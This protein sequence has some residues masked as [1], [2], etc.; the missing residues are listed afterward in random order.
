[1][2]VHHGVSVDKNKLQQRIAEYE[3]ELKAPRAQKTSASNQ[4]KRKTTRDGCVPRPRLVLRDVGAHEELYEATYRLRCLDE[5][6]AVDIQFLECTELIMAKGVL[7]DLLRLDFVGAYLSDLRLLVSSPWNF[8]KHSCM[9]LTDGYG[10]ELM[11]TGIPMLILDRDNNKTTV[12]SIGSGL[13]ACLTN[14]MSRHGTCLSQY[15]S[16]FVPLTQHALISDQARSQLHIVRLF[17]HVK[18]NSLHRGRISRAD[19][20]LPPR[21]GA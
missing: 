17:I 19:S 20:F 11:S 15:L 1:M 9:T 12:C 4:S 13:Q 5:D 21:Y 10:T 18:R 7:P 2:V 3:K 14:T 8:L 6:C 16:G